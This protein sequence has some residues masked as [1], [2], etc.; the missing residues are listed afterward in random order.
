M[1]NLIEEKE[2]EQVEA[3]PD[4]EPQEKSPLRSKSLG[5]RRLKMP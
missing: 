3:T 5:K 2:P 4:P 1:E